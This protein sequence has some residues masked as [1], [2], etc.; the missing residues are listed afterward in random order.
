MKL[1]V[2]LPIHQVIAKVF[3]KIRKIAFE[4]I[5]RRRDFRKETYGCGQYRKVNV[6][7]LCRFPKGDI[8]V[9]ISHTTLAAITDLYL[10]HRF[11]LLGSGWV[12]VR[13]GMECNGLEDWR[14]PDEETPV[15]D[16]AGHWLVGRINSSNLSYSQHVWSLIDGDRYV[17]IDWHIDFKSGYRWKENVWYRDITFG[18]LPGVDVKVPWELAR[19]Q[20][21]PQLAQAYAA[22]L[23]GVEGFAPAGVYADEFRHQILDFI[24][25][26]PPRFGVN[27]TCSMDVGIR[28][29][30]WLLAYDLFVSAGAVFDEQFDDVFKL[31]VYQHGKHIVHNLEWH[32]VYRGNH[33]LADIVGLL[34]VSS[35]LASDPEIDAWLAFG[36]Q[37]LINEVDFQFY[38]D[39]SNF[40]A[41]TSYHRLSAELVVYATAL[42][43]GLPDTKR[44]ALDG[45]DH[46]LIKG[47]PSLSPA[48]IKKILIPGSADVHSP[49]PAWYWVRLERMAEFTSA[50]MRPD[51]QSPQ[52]GDNDSGRFFKLAPMYESLTVKEAKLRYANLKNF[53]GLSLDEK[54][55]LEVHNDH[56]HLIAAINGFLRREDFANFSSDYVFESLVI[57]LISA[58]VS[59]RSSPV[60][61]AALV[62]DQSEEILSDLLEEKYSRSSNHYEFRSLM[63]CNDEQD[64]RTNL[65]LFAYPDF[66][67][68]LYKSE[69]IYLLFRC[70]SIGLNGLGAH[71]HND[72][73]SV[74]LW[75]GGHPVIVDPGTY[76]YTPLPFRRNEF[77]SISAHFSPHIAGSEP[78]NIS[79]NV[80]QL[81]NE[82][83]AKCTYFSAVGLT[84]DYEMGEGYV[85]RG[86]FITREIIKI[87]D[88]T[89]N[90]EAPLVTLLPQKYKISRGYGWIEKNENELI[91]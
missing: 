53:R 2:R 47:V 88:W 32:P 69:I 72:Q 23:N 6:P 36:V 56:R 30:N 13:H 66:G 42:V 43:V 40:E 22:A 82:A 15:F 37:E 83:K 39:G 28:V 68:Y 52:V 64:L 91:L 63:A 33:Y 60:Q 73:L 3:G 24:A 19:M 50:I 31:S 44:S 8:C 14:Y 54:Y 85:H 46:R 84:G 51:K 86:I 74:E 4:Q 70:G 41:S 59:C 61:K 12:N 10:D 71:A 34:F 21:L 48:S 58:N 55:L 77:R 17:P 89:E 80:F 79:G 78:G 26:N 27:W 90:L 35:Y 87:F 62:F 76:L 1:V 5:M 65:Q 20:H 38:A 7:L 67:L 9:S 18:R 29:A 57:Q 25:S 45:Y 81:G 11:D 16:N 75:I 49:F